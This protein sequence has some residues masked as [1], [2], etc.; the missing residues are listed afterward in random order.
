MGRFRAARRGHAAVLA[1]PRKGR[2]RALSCAVPVGLGYRLTALG[3]AARLLKAIPAAYAVAMPLVALVH[4]AL[5]QREADWALE[6]LRRHI[7]NAR[8]A[9]F[10]GG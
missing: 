7:G 3:A 6:A 4:L 5:R 1:A 10:E 2:N 9:P 8:D